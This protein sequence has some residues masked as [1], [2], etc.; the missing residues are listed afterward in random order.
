MTTA[1]VKF[2][3]RR[4]QK[5]WNE[6]HMNSRWRTTRSN[7][8]RFISSLLV[9][10]NY[11]CTIVSSKSYKLTSFVLLWSG[12]IGNILIDI[13]CASYSVWL[14]IMEMCQRIPSRNLLNPQLYC[15][16]LLVQVEYEMRKHRNLLKYFCHSCLSLSNE[17]KNRRTRSESHAENSK[18]ID[19]SALFRTS[20]DCLLPKICVH[21]AVECQ[22][23]LRKYLTDN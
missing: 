13:L 20:R 12:S 10:I 4:V 15:L 14:W 5:A 3:G 19:V 9:V 18:S 22:Q 2:Q 17:G 7:C 23:M 21:A 8:M 11:Y 1:I 16:N 6:R